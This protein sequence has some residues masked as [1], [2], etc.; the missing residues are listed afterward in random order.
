MAA[1]SKLT[2]EICKSGLRELMRL[3][4]LSRHTIN[5]ICEAKPRVPCVFRILEPMQPIGTI[6][7]AEGDDDTRHPLL[8]VQRVL[9]ISD[10]RTR[11]WEK[12][13]SYRT[14]RAAKLRPACASHTFPSRGRSHTPQRRRRIRYTPCRV[15]CR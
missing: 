10:E 13:L 5:A 9:L 14:T 7:N 12:K 8:P 1:E 2:D 4:G 11:I 6:M 3:T 15:M